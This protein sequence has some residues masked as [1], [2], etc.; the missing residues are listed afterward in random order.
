MNYLQTCTSANALNDQT[1]IPT[2]K[3][4]Q[5]WTTRKYHK[6]NVQSMVKEFPP[7]YFSVFRIALVSQLDAA[8]IHSLAH[9][10]SVHTF[11]SS[12]ETPI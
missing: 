12:M 9:Q 10:S 11:C 6:Q 2:K 1:H 3:K 7:F 8:S 4:N 5:L